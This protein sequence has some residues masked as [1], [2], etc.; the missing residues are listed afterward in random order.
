MDTKYLLTLKTILET[1]SFQKAAKK[2]NYTQSTVTFHIQQLEL[3]FSVKLFEKIGRK[4]CLTE[5]GHEILPHI[6][7][8]LQETEWIQNYGNDISEFNG[9]LKIGMPDF[10]LCYAMT[11]LIAIF[12][13]K[14]PNTQ[15]I[16]NSLDCHSIRDSVIN[17]GIDLGIHCDIGGY[18]HAFIEEPLS[19]YNSI[20]VASPSIDRQTLDFITP[21]Q[22]KN[23]NLISSDPHSLHQKRLNQYLDERDI[24]LNKNIK[25]LNIEATKISVMNNLGIAYLPD[26]TVEK[27]LS[28]GALIQIETELDN[29]PVPVVCTYHKNKWISPAMELFKN[30]LHENLR[31]WLSA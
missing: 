21:H 15:L 7:L 30:L 12:Q 6:N 5:A 11:P 4:M 9:T 24:L 17:G 23:L 13:K 1:G 14:A 18:P 3:E 10:L 31:P 19:F 25:M 29:I 28:E 20:L 16:I 2:L 26:F 22:R 8:I 27:E